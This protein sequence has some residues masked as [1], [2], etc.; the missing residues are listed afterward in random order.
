M[1]VHAYRL[2]GVN[3]WH[4]C[5]YSQQCVKVRI[6]RCTERGIDGQAEGEGKFRR[7]VR[8]KK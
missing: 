7:A 1:T 2:V 4:V 5:R 6:S 8:Q 3:L